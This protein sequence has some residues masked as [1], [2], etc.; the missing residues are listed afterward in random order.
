MTIGSA[1][2]VTPI[3]Q[4][5]EQ[6]YPHLRPVNRPDF[7]G[8][9]KPTEQ[10][11]PYGAPMRGNVQ[12]PVHSAEAVTVMRARQAAANA[13]PQA[14]APSMDAD[15]LQKIAALERLV[16]ALTVRVGL[17]MDEREASERERQSMQARLD[18]LDGTALG[19]A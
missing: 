5:V 19:A 14:I 17:L 1:G 15:S 16:D 13:T 9:P 3:V 4:T 2:L 11:L 6:V 18:V 7:R 10:L 12:R 8:A